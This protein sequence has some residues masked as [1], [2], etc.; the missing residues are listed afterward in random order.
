MCL[1]NHFLSSS[2]GDNQR[3]KGMTNKQTNKQTSKQPPYF[4]Y[5]TNFE[6]AALPSRHLW[7]PVAENGDPA[8]NEREATK[9]RQRCSFALVQ[10]EKY[11]F[12]VLGNS[13]PNRSHRDVP[14]FGRLDRVSTAF[15][16]NWFVD[17]T[18]FYCGRSFPDY[19]F[20]IRV[21]YSYF[22]TGVY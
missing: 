8:F 20:T 21:R 7:N 18:G 15:H 17:W 13:T 1:S 22:S 4:I 3:E 5:K 2:R 11:D 16:V 10:L 9:G 12:P 19:F 6:D 14:T